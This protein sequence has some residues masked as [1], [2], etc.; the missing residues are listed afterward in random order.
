MQNVRARMPHDVE[1]IPSHQDLAAAEGE[2]KDAS[3]RHLDEKVLDF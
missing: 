2:V 1:E 3:I